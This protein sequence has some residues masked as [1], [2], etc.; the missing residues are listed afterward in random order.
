[1]PEQFTRQQIAA[2]RRDNPREFDAM[3]E[4]VIYGE[5]HPN[6]PRVHELDEAELLM[7]EA[8]RQKGLLS[9]E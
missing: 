1:M 7:V 3:F 9:H 2:L 6:P 5:Q 4:R 8:M